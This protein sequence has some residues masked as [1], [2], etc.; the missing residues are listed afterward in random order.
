MLNSALSSF[1]TSIA[2]LSRIPIPGDWQT[3]DQADFRLLPNYFWMAG[4]FLGLLQG[5]AALI[6]LKLLPIS[7]AIICILMFQILLTGAFH[8]DGWADVADSCGGY[9]LQ[10]K[11]EIMKDSRLGTFGVSSL[12]LLFLFRFETYSSLTES[13]FIQ[14]FW[15][16]FLVN[17]WSRWS[18]V[19]L[20]R[21]LPYL[22]SRGQGI[23]GDFDPPSFQSTI[24]GFVLLTIVS[25]LTLHIVGVLLIPILVLLCLL[26]GYL[27]FK[28]H[29]GGVTGDALG[30][31]TIFTEITLLVIL[32]VSL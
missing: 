15:A 27:F 22:S 29:L 24:I 28:Q 31:V 20:L 3:K 9:T 4:M 19:Q 7:I 14:V 5:C 2:F 25:G 18:S 13:G 32:S 30:A 10:R 1:F 26:L 8:E 23:A 17:G 11:L 6:S 21:F 12:I 16:L